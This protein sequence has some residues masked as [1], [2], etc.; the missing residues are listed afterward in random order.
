MRHATALCLTVLAL[1]LSACQLDRTPIGSPAPGRGTWDVKPL[2]FCPGDPVTVSWNF[3]ALPRTVDN[4]RPEN[5]G[6]GTLTACTDSRMCPASPAGVCLDNF[7]CTN[8]LSAGAGRC[9]APGGCLPPF[10]VTITA[11]T[12]AIDPPVSGERN[13]TVGERQVT[14][15]STTVFSISGNWVPPLVVFEE[16]KTA[17]ALDPLRQTPQRVDF[18]FICAGS[19]PTYARV[20]MT[21]NPIASAHAQIGLVTNP[22]G[23]TIVVAT[24]DP[25]RGPVTLRPG[26]TT[27]AFNGRIVGTWVVELSPLDPLRRGLPPRCLPE[28]IEGAWPDLS[29]TLGLTCGTD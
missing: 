17:R 26:E 28:R 3:S 24:V 14:P 11:D 5:G 9:A 23:H 15:P 19:G 13:D 6:Y 12:V 7:C 21:A 27:T 8:A 16:S 10:S 1:L 29:L 2:L 18:P 20:D 22:T 25:A 4:C